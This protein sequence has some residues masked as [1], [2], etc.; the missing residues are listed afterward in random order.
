VPAL[1]TILLFWLVF[2]D[3]IFVVFLPVFKNLDGQDDVDVA[4]NHRGGVVVATTFLDESDQRQPAK[5]YS[6]RAVATGIGSGSI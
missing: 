5:P 2:L 1:D 4:T 6:T 3:T